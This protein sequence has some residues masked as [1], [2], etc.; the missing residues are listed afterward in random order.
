MA[1]IAFDVMLDTGV[2]VDPLPLWENEWIRPERF[3]NPALIETIKRE[4]LRV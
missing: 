3:G 4:G 1:E 2:L